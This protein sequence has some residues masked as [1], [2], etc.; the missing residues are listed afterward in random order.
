M[1]PKSKSPLRAVGYTRRS[2]HREGFGLNAQADAI[3][4]W[5]A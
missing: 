2:Q 3:R 5:A 1:S 4:R